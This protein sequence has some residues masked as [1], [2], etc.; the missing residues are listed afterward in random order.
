LGKVPQTLEKW[1]VYAGEISVLGVL[2]CYSVFTAILPF[3]VLLFIKKHRKT[4][5]MWIHERLA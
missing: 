3:G 4:C 1:E 5:A 2:R